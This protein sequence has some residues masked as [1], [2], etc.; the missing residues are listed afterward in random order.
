MVNHNFPFQG[1]IIALLISLGDISL[2]LD[3]KN[4]RKKIINTLGPWFMQTSLMRTEGP[5]LTRI[6]R[7]EKNRVT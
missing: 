6:L 7:I 4:K 2:T 5:H 1:I 3:G